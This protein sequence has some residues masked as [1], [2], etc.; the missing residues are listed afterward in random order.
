MDDPSGYAPQGYYDPIELPDG[1]IID[2]D[3]PREYREATTVATDE[4]YNGWTN[5]ETWAVNLWLANDEPAYRT[6]RDIAAPGNYDYPE[7]EMRELVERITVD[8][9]ADQYENE[10]RERDPEYTAWPLP[11]FATDLIRASLARVD[12]HAIVEAF[13]EE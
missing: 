2:H 9:I 1:S 10:R 3:D 7:D 12:W 5:R 6:A 8:A 11:G 13:A 4:T